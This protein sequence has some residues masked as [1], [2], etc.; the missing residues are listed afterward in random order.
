MALLVF[1]GTLFAF[2]ALGIPVA[3]VLTLCAIALMMFMGQWDPVT[4]SQTMLMG[5][6]NYPLMAIPFFMLAGEVMAKGGLAIRIV[7]FSKLLIGRIR[8]GLGYTTIVASIL[9]AGLSGSAVADAAVQGAIL[10]PLMTANGYRSDRSAGII[11]S[12]SIIAPIIP[13][14]I[15][16]IVLA[17]TVNL[18]V[19]R[20]FMAGIAPGLYIGIALMFAWWFVVK[21]DNYQDQE[22]FSKEEARRITIDSLPALVMPIL[23]VGGIRFGIFTPT[24]AGAFAT[25][26]AIAVSFI[27]YKEMKLKD[28]VDV[29]VNA[30]KS[31]AVVMF[32]VSAATAVGYYITLAQVPFQLAN[33]LGG[34]LENRL[35]LIFVINIFL[36][37][38]G[39]VMDITPNILIFAPVLYPVI[40]RA[41]I[42]PYF[43]GIM[44]VLN[45]CIGLIT[46]PVGVVLYIGCS[47]AKIKIT[48]MVRGVMPFLVVQLVVL[49]LIILFPQLVTTPMNLL[50]R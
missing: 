5:T 48:E 11:C 8:G 18:S 49:V 47:T 10:I 35:L 22:T 42:D 50:M 25:M 14:S 23:I 40:M 13:P 9:M 15:P 26:Y 3:I 28:M 29:F 34:L 1:G 31:T 21:K 30:A 39:M 7:K 6:N 46:P 44:M 16:M 4:I 17:T 12:S 45:L 43:F 33:L 24:E 41:G 32:V 2:L 19:T 27:Y 38:M 20:L 36:F 37:I